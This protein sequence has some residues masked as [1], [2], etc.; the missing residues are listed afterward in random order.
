LTTLKLYAGK[1]RKTQGGFIGA[2]SVLTQ[3]KEGPKRRR[4][5]LIVDG[6]PA[7]REFQPKLFESREIV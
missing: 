6:A 4:V 1:E 7:R 2:D 3:L 5:G